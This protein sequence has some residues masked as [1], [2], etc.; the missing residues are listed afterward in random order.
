MTIVLEDRSLRQCRKIQNF[1]S[2]HNY[3][4]GT[5]RTRVFAALKSQGI[6]K[7]KRTEEIIAEKTRR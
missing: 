4:A 2:T 3:F 7:K 6:E 5:M 1:I